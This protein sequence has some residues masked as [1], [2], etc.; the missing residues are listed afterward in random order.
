MNH[1]DI[2]PEVERPVTQEDILYSEILALAAEISAKLDAERPAKAPYNHSH[3]NWASE[4]HHPCL[5]HLVH[6]RVDW[7]DR[8]PMDIEGRWRTDE[9]KRIEWEVTKWLGDIRYKID[10]S[11]K[12][13]TT[14]DIPE[15]A[16]LKISGRIDGMIPIKRK[17]PEPFSDMKEIKVEI[18]TV[19][20]NYWNSTKTVADI[21]RHPKFWIN[22]IPSQLNTYLAISNDPGGLLII[23]TFGKRPRI[24]PMLFDQDLWDHDQ[25]RV[26]KVNAHVAAGT[27]P[28]PIPFDATV[29][30]MCDFAHICNPVQ[31]TKMCQ[32]DPMDI[33]TLE[34]YLEFKEM[35]DKFKAIHAELIGDKK[36]PGK[37]RGMDA[38]IEDIEIAT[39]RHLRKVYDIPKEEKE[40]FLTGEDEVVVTTI[41]RIG[42]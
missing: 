41:S 30:G 1:L 29:C 3:N 20:P 12:R 16:D 4:I 36:K 39:R 24:I 9:G 27:Y 14:D 17:L 42:T 38:I 21:R 33:F 34:Q 26:R 28:E 19:N 5:K 2:Q 8:K 32:V 15:Y 25:A 13:Y 10:D 35:A 18:K 37:Y 31:T 23:V 11:Q 7:A 6:C 40:K 22:K